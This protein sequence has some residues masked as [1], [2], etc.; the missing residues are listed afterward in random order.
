MAKVE[1]QG[2]TAEEIGQEEEASSHREVGMVEEATD[3]V[4]SSEEF[5]RRLQAKGASCRRILGCWT[6][7]YQKQV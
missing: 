1:E 4:M 5:A 6:P 7:P 3:Q 2:T